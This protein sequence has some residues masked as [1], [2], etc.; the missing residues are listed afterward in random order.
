MKSTTTMPALFASL[1]FIAAAGLFTPARADQWDKRTIMTT[2]EPIQV[3]NRMLDPGTYVFK[4]ADSQSDRH[5]VQI[6]NHGSS[7]GRTKLYDALSYSLQYLEKG[8]MDKKTLVVVSDG[9]DN[10]SSLSRKEAMRGV[11][12]S[13]A[14]IY[15]IG[16]FDESDPDSH[17]DVLRQL[18]QVSGGEYFRLHETSEI[19]PVCKKLATDIRSRYTI[20]YVPSHPGLSRSVHLVKVTAFAPSGEKLIVRTRSRYMMP[21]RNQQTLRLKEPGP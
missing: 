15:T 11:Q 20:A 7:E 14:T 3:P 9:G 12:E 17:S 21:E 18:A 13:R 16:I 10:A 2:S 1:V 8:R 4:L 19:V 5:I 6:F